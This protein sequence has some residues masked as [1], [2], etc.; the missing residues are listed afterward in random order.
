MTNILDTCDIESYFDAH[1]KPKWEHYMWLEMDSLEKNHTWDLVPKPHV[2]NIIKCWWV[3]H[4]KFTSQGVIEHQKIILLQKPSL[5]K[6]ELTTLIPL[7]L[8]PRW[9]LL[10]WFVLLLVTL[11][12]RSTK[13]MLKVP[14]FMVTYLKKYIWTIPLF[15]WYIPSLFLHYIAHYM[16]LNRSLG[17]DSRRLISSL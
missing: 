14:F 12:G 8:F 16:V 9:T 11:D 17:L 7:L 1:G 5:N 6:K 13:W 3:Y 4:T 10:N 15:L 2:N